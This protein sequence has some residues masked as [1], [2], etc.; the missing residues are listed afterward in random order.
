MKVRCNSV[1][2][3]DSNLHTL[4]KNAAAKNHF[5][6][7]IGKEYVVFGLIFGF[8]D[9]GCGCFAQILSDYDHL[10][11]VPIILFDIVDNRISNYWDLRKSVDGN[12]TLWPS[13]FYLEYYHDDLFEEVPDIVAD[14]KKVKQ[15]IITEFE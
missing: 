10:I 9:W 6:I 8:D 12:I 13:S 15:S 7:T 3:S 14:F 5:N 1:K 2:I 11:Q 4:G